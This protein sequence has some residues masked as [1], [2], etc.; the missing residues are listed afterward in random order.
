MEGEA[1]VAILQLLDSLRALA[2]TVLCGRVRAKI[3]RC[4]GCA[5]YLL[6]EPREEPRHDGGGRERMGSES[7]EREFISTRTSDMMNSGSYYSVRFGREDSGSHPVR[8]RRF[9]IAC[10]KISQKVETNNSVPG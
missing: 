3:K 6:L 5:V 8:A 7:G 2:G 4:S 9:V 1:S 10:R